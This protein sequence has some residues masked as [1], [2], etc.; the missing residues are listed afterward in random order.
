MLRSHLDWHRE[1]EGAALPEGAFYPNMPPVLLNDFL[2]NR[3]PE[4]RTALFPGVG[5][6]GLLE[7]LE[8]A[9]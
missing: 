8:Y 2:A 7:P 1:V 6:I 9:L 3:Q 5:G 4:P